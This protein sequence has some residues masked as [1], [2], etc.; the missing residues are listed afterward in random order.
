[1]LRPDRGLDV[2]AGKGKERA[3]TLRGGVVGVILDARGR[4][5]FLLPADRNQRIAKLAEWNEALDIYPVAVR[6]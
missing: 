3:V 5:P 6:S 1:M 2:G 4:Q